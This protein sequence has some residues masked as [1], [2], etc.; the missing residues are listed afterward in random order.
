MFVYKALLCVVIGIFI[1]KKR[2]LDFQGS[3]SA[4]IMGILVVFF[5]GL[6][7]LSLM[8]VFLVIT[9]L[10]TKYKYKRKLALEV[11]ETN[12][13]RRSVINVLA[14]GLI[15]TAIATAFYFNTDSSTG[16]LLAA[17]YI[18]AVAS[19]TGDTLSSELGVLS[20]GEPYL[21]TNFK[22]VPTGT[23]GGISPLGELVGVS[24]AL[25]IGVSAW[26]LGLADIKIAVLAAVVGGSVGFHVDSLLG[27]IFERRGML[28][29]ASVNFLSTIAGALAGLFMALI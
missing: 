23:D 17:A 13:G 28:G 19:I 10:S 8:L 4:V 5:V 27:A 9:Y 3:F 2:I 11:A 15:P 16:L 14:N 6:E 22:R 20:R 21:I 1:Y 25:L 26:A 7:W 29:N 24:G 12:H 18:A